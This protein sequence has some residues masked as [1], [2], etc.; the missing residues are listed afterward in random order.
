MQFRSRKQKTWSFEI[1]ITSI[2]TN[3]KQL[4]LY[5]NITKK[6]VFMTYETLPK[7]IN[8][9]SK[10]YHDGI[11]YYFC[12]SMTIKEKNAWKIYKQIQKFDLEEEINIILQ[13]SELLS[14][15]TYNHIIKDL[16]K[17]KP[18]HQKEN[19]I[20]ALKHI[21]YKIKRGKYTYTDK[22]QEVAL[23]PGI[24]TFL[25]GYSPN[26]VFY[27]GKDCGKLLMPELTKLDKIISEISKSKNHKVKQRYIKKANRKRKKIKNMK[28]ELHNQTCNL[29]VNY[30]NTIL[31]PDF[32]V[33]G[34]AKILE[35]KIS[36]KSV[37][38]MYNLGFYQFSQKLRAK[39]RENNCKVLSVSEAYTSKTCGRCGWI[40]EFLK[41]KKVFEC[42]KCH[43]KIDRDINGAR[44]IFLRNLRDTSIF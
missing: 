1:P 41:G 18:R 42:D 10:I 3:N 33:K 13:R 29:L 5:K 14:N 9:P 36:T 16:N 15:S 19:V 22:K 43:L 26:E 27:I 37:R 6:T 44:N 28:T 31:L 4:F 35:R 32:N 24:R 17:I 23:D 21:E 39:T 34:I 25:T 40:D 30:S 20:K 38:N 7:E 8:Y 11:D 2:K 12:I